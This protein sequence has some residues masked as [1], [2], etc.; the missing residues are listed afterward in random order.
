MADKNYDAEVPDT[1]WHR[2]P[3]RR[4]YVEVGTAK[5]VAKKTGGN[6]G[7]VG[8]RARALKRGHG[9][10]QETTEMRAERERQSREARSRRAAS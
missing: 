4:K 8:R 2:A 1:G 5:S 9:G 7:G 10:G 3:L 6:S